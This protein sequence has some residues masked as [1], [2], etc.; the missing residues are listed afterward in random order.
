M[1]KDPALYKK[2]I[3]IAEDYFGPA[4]SRYIDRLVKSHFHKT[5]EKLSHKDMPE[6]IEWTK[7]TVA[8]LTEDQIVIDEFAHRLSLVDGKA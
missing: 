4:A 1:T 5:P 8:M 6:L 3:F 2:V 7:L